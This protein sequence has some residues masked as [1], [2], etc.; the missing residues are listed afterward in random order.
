MLLFVIFKGIIEVTMLQ[1]NT[2]NL[3]PEGLK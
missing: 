2:E 3:L 1:D